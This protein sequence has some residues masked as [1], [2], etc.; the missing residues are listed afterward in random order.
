MVIH[1]VRAGKTQSSLLSPSYGH[2]MSDFCPLFIL[3][4]SV[5][6][7]PKGSETG[8]FQLFETLLQAITQFFQQVRLGKYSVLVQRRR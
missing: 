8:N 7:E 6:Q 5:L 2:E 3:F 4:S 1:T